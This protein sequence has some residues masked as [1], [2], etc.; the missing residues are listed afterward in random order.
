MGEPQINGNK[1]TIRVMPPNFSKFTKMK[2][3]EEFEN[4]EIKLKKDTQ[5]VIP[6][7]VKFN[8]ANGET[9]TFGEDIPYKC[10]RCLTNEVY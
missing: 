10:R 8:D 3:K 1:T 4:I 2:K 7:D 9:L 5:M 6:A